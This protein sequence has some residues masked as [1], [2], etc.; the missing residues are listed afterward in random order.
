MFG[1]NYNRMTDDQLREWHQKSTADTSAWHDQIREARDFTEQHGSTR[2][3]RRIIARCQR[4]HA[5]SQRH[6]RAIEAAARCRSV[7]L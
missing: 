1:P 5:R 3:V 6:V 4:G 2:A 7:R